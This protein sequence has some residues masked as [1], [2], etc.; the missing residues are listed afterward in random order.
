MPLFANPSKIFLDPSSRMAHHEMQKQSI[1]HS[2]SKSERN[3]APGYT[4]GEVTVPSLGAEVDDQ[5]ILVFSEFLEKLRQGYAMLPRL[6][7][8]SWPQAA[9]P[10][11]PPKVLGLRQRKRVCVPAALAEV[12]TQMIDRPG[13][14][15]NQ[16]KDGYGSVRKLTECPCHGNYLTGDEDGQP[17]QLS[18]SRTDP[19][20]LCPSPLPG[21]PPSSEGMDFRKTRA[22]QGPTSSMCS[23]LEPSLDGGPGVISPE[24]LVP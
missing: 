21:P 13:D 3:S 22:F 20:G 4:L 10:P 19:S 9:L 18:L 2:D 12:A 23:P 7:S 24:A 17:P 1:P 14:R 5:R 16:I 6:I 15:Q 11:Q 8:N